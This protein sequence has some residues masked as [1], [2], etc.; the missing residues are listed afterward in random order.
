MHRSI[1]TYKN[2]IL[3]SLKRSTSAP[4][5]KETR[6]EIFAQVNFKDSSKR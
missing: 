5:S 3:N 6:I 1:K 4:K 2:K